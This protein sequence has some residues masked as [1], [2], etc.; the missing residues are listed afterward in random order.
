MTISEVLEY[1]LIFIGF[2]FTC[3]GAVGMLRFCDFYTKLHASGIND[4]MGVLFIT[5]SAILFYGFSINLIKLILILII[6]YITSTTNTYILSK[7][8]FGNS[9]DK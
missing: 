9:H 8:S 6:S 1:M 3:F 5:T 7:S 4:T 2:I